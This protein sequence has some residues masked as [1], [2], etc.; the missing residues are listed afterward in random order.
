MFARM[1]APLIVFAAGELGHNSWV[2]KIFLAS[3][4]N[5]WLLLH[6][7]TFEDSLDC[8]VC[9]RWCSGAVVQH[10]RPMM[11][12][13][14]L[15]SDCLGGR[16]ILLVSSFWVSEKWWSRDSS[17]DKMSREKEQQRNH[18]HALNGIFLEVI[19]AAALTASAAVCAL[20]C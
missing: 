2:Q 9:L 6:D 11:A 16:T 19:D 12:F 18:D 7:V 10:E 3:Q 4:Q 8:M 13:G 20:C 14:V 5:S 15:S 1:E 17:S